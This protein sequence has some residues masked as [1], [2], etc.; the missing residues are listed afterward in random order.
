MRFHST[1]L[2]LLF[3]LLAPSQCIASEEINIGSKSFTEQLLLGE[4][5]AQLIEKKTELRV[6]RR[7]H[8]GGT[9]LVFDAIKNGEL[10]LYPEYTGTGLVNIL[11]LSPQKDPKKVYATV[12]AKFQ[13]NWDL[14]WLKPFGFNN[15][16][17]LAVHKKRAPYASLNNL[18][19]LKAYGKKLRFGCPHEFLDR[20]DGMPGLLSHYGFEIPR[21][22]VV[23]LIC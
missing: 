12:K 18:S 1:L 11:N 19:E 14:H 22:N 21:Q 3:L 15:T 4:I 17:A 7:F 9:K 8:L 23:A 16:Y 20:P 13:K 10:D 2:T 5:L 6:R